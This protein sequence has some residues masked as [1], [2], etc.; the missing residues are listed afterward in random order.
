[1]E[2]RSDGAE[3]RPRPAFFVSIPPRKEQNLGMSCDGPQQFTVNTLKSGTPGKG[4]EF[5]G[6]F[7]LQRK[8]DKTSRH[9]N[10]FRRLELADKTGSFGATLFNDQPLFRE[11]ETFQ[12]GDILKTSGIVDWFNEAFSP[13]LQSLEKIPPEE[14]ERRNLIASLVET[15][16]ENPEKLYLEL[17]QMVESLQPEALRLTVESVFNEYGDRFKNAPAAI[18]MHHAY[19]HGLL[20]HTVHMGRAAQALLPIYPEVHPHLAM[21]GILLHDI[22]K[23]EE[24]EGALSFRKSS[25]GIL[26]G[27]VVLGYRAARKAALRNHLDTDLQERLE[28]IILSHQGELEWGAATMAATP[29]GI[30]VSMVDNLDAKMGMVQRLLRQKTEN[31]NLSDRHPGL[32]TQVLLRPVKEG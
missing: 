25:T 32:K 24:Y 4:R 9:G 7:I 12:E 28:H 27:H 29:E 30:F 23:I 10:P 22:G 16:P 15:S 8:E 18:S 2:G 11:S 20:E 14:A 17:I 13:K 3:N 21:A 19:R 1:M 26:H 5:Q 31:Q 6:L